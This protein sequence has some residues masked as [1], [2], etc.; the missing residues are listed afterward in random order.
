MSFERNEE[1]GSF[2][3]VDASEILTPVQTDHFL[4]KLNNELGLAQLKVR[5]ARTREVELEEA[6]M[7]ARTPLLVD[8][9]C[10][11]VGRRA[12][13][14]SQKQQDAW[15]AEKIPDPYWALRTAQVVRRNA[16]DYAEQV[17]AQVEI[18]RSLN[19]NAK[20]IYDSYRGGGR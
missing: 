15:F 4:K 2:E 3:F 14:V 20:A 13:Q 7:R 11:E 1:T 12:G 18:M 9:A 17:K 5:K 10:P 6:Y 16:V 19:V 8:A